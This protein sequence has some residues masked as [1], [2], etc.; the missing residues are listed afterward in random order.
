MEFQEFETAIDQAASPEAIWRTLVAFLRV[1]G[2]QDIAYQHIPPLGA[3]DVQVQRIS[4]DGFPEE[5]IAHYLAARA[6]GTTPVTIHAQR[7]GEPVYWDEIDSLKP[8]TPA[9]QAHLAT[10]RE[11]GF[12]YGL[13]IPVFGPN[14]RNGMFGLRL[15]AELP[16]LAPEDL[17]TVNWVCQAT[18]LRYSALLLPSL[19]EP[20]NLSPRESEVLGW[21]ARGKSNASI[22]SI[23]GIST[24]TVDAHLRRIYLKLGVFDR[25]TAALRGVGFGLIH[26]DG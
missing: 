23:L 19:G 11:A 3:P 24:H 15:S 22:G 13:A 21:V 25:I 14:G 26:S 7:N 10:L 9:E 12:E 2:L 6:K 17:R 16:R 1:R 18:H 8:L 20:P 5:W 4:N